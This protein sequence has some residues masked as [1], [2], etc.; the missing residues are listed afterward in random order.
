MGHQFGGAVGLEKHY[1]WDI[2]EETQAL[3]CW[4]SWDIRVPLTMRNYTIQNCPDRFASS[5]SLIGAALEMVEK[6]K[7]PNSSFTAVLLR[8]ARISNVGE[9]WMMGMYFFG[10]NE[11]LDE[12]TN[13][14]V[15]SPLEFPLGNGGPGPRHFLAIW[16]LWVSHLWPNAF[17]RGILV[18]I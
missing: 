17:F 3:Q 6:L 12:A 7:D 18:A 8:P 9:L 4:D 10:E 16:I 11:N 15:L 1:R 14:Y 2:W 13:I 5:P